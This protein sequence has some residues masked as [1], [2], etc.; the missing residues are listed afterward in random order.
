MP[1]AAAA[2]RRELRL[3]AGVSLCY[4]ACAAVVMMRLWRAPASS[5]VTGNPNDADQFAWY[6]RYG[7]SAVAHLRLPSLVTGAM[8][9]PQGINVMANPSMLLPAVVLAPLTLL[10][11][12]QVSLTV[13]MTLGFAGSAAA[14]FWVLRRWEAAAGPA[15]FGGLVYGFCPALTQSAIGH[16]DLQ[17]AVLPPLIADAFFRL[18]TGRYQRGP[19]RCGAR[20]GLLA[21]AQLF[22]A[23]ELL[24]EVCAGLIVAG[25]TLAASRPRA[26][27]AR[28]REVTAGLAAGL[29]VTALI[30]GPVLWTQFLGP[31]HGSGSPYSPDFFKNDLA[32]FVQPSSSEWIHTGSSAA[33]AGRFQGGPAEYLAYL[34][35]SAL[36]VSLMLAVRFWRLLAVRVSAVVF[37]VLSVLSLGGTLL[38]GGHG[39]SWLKLPWYWVQTLPVLGSAMPDRFSIVADCA[40]AALLALGLDAWLRRAPKSAVWFV[41]ALALAVALPLIPRP[42]PATSVEPLP[43]G[44]RQAFAALHLP[45]GAS[46][47]VVPIPTG[48]LT[49][50]M[51]WQAGTGTPAS[52]YGGYFIGPAWNGQVYVGGNGLPAAGQYLNQLWAQSAGVTIGSQPVRPVPS[53]AQLLA[54]IATWHPAAVVVV[55]AV[56]SALGELLTALL[57]PPSTVNGAVLGWRLVR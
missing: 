6:L 5:I 11:G 42:L 23:E 20:L 45:A 37:A 14:M 22:I 41:P 34:G 8:N 51:R 55:T 49:Q 56:H 13:L 27:R 3:A 18:L 25:V 47:L 29:A 50:A 2:R 48:T 12:P 21:T 24:L 19:A 32:G 4:L 17:F 26:V 57:G 39:H 15:A 54:A 16:Y 43:A 7:A 10:A 30:A 46:V 9:A 44:W 35:G 33:F 53:S 31:L 52:L 1:G 38:L 36:V 28:V 40:V